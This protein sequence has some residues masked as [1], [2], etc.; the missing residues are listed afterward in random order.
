MEKKKVEHQKGNL[1]TME[2]QEQ[3][4]LS[5]VLSNNGTFVPIG[6]SNIMNGS[7]G[8]GVSAKDVYGVIFGLLEIKKDH[9]Y[10]MGDLIKHL[11]ER[12]INITWVGKIKMPPGD[13]DFSIR[14]QFTSEFRQR[15][16]E[17]VLFEDAAEKQNFE[18]ILKMIDD[19]VTLHDI[20]IH[21]A[22][23]Q[24]GYLSLFLYGSVGDSPESI[25]VLG[26]EIPY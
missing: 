6:A 12:N 20:T 26:L 8:L 21:P 5:T 19:T 15:F 23:N 7:G 14:D 1:I 2:S 22:V 18:D 16:L 3:L 17:N 9:P 13:I 4:V 25:R 11:R 10:K 24:G